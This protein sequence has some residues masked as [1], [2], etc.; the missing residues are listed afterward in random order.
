MGNLML[1]AHDLGVGSCWIHR[2]KEEFES[3]GAGS[4][5]NHSVLRMNMRESDIVLLDM[6]MEIILT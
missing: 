4:F 5:S 2:A 1:A 3:D 6:L